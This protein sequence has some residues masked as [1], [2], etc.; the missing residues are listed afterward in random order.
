MIL[1]MFG[2]IVVYQELDNKNNNIKELNESLNVQQKQI[3]KLQNN[4]TDLISKLNVSEAKL[5]EEK[6]QKEKLD[7]FGYL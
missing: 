3:L 6:D 4:L 5:S 7:V 1:V 2:S